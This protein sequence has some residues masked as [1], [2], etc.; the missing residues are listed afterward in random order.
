MPGRLSALWNRLGWSATDA[1]ASHVGHVRKCGG[2]VVQLQGSGSGDR[3][4]LQIRQYRELFR[5]SS[6]ELGIR[7]MAF[8][9]SVSLIETMNKS[10]AS[11]LHV[12]G[13]IRSSWKARLDLFRYRRGTFPFHWAGTGLRLSQRVVAP[14]NDGQFAGWLEIPEGSS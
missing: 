1:I 4:A 12:R 2:N 11:A 7:E 8:P 14:E 9:Q 10:G 3:R 6:G 5:T 13:Q